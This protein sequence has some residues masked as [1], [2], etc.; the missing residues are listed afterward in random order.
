MKNVTKQENFNQVCVWQGTI[1]GEDRVSEFTEWCKDTF[2]VRVQYLEEYKTLPD[3]ND[4]GNPVEGTG[5]RNDVIFA[6]H[7]EDVNKFVVSRFEY[8]I[9][10]IEDVI[11]NNPDIYDKRI[12]KYGTW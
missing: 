2:D 1:I 9:R 8:G 10:W 4:F 11:S 12:K 7:D 6:I 5:G 3:V